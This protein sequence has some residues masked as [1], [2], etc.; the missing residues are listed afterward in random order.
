MSI[1]Y[2][3]AKLKCY[4]SHGVLISH[5]K[6]EAEVGT[7]LLAHLPGAR[8]SALAA[9]VLSHV[10]TQQLPAELEADAACA[11][12]RVQANCRAAHPVVSASFLAETSVSSPRKL[13]IFSI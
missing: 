10:P 6:C 4:Q 3:E 2:L 7:L 1:L 5:L 12:H 13:F 9:G 11:Q 8:A